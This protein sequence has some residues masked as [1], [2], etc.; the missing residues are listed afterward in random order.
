MKLTRE[1]ALELHRQMWRD[2]LAEL[3]ETGKGEEPNIIRARSEFKKE[4]C[5]NHLPG[6]PV[7]EDCILCEYARQERIRHD[8]QKPRC[9]YCPINWGRIPSFACENNGVV[10]SHSPISEILALPERKVE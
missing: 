1:R 7:L 4:W 6:T 10:W 9:H 3:G 5:E 8:F 2:M